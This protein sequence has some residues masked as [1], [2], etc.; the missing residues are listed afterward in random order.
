MLDINPIHDDTREVVNLIRNW[1]AGSFHS[2]CPTNSFTT[3]LHLLETQH[4]T[5]LLYHKASL[6]NNNND[7]NNYNNNNN[8]NNNNNDN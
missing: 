8:N 2:L 4:P 1:N 5:L 7:N 3:A 6:E